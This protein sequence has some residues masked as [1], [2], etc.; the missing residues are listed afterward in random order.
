MLAMDSASI[1]AWLQSQPGGH[2]TPEPGLGEDASPTAMLAMGRLA[3]R[4]EEVVTT[5]SDCLNRPQ[6]QLAFRQLL[7]HLS[8]GRRLRL[9]SW[10]I[11]R[12]VPDGPQ[13]LAK[14]MD[15]REPPIGVGL[16]LFEDARRLHRLGLLEAIFHPDRIARVLAACERRGRP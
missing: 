7:Q 8:L 12:P 9:L 14:L 4:L 6:V 10:L 11:E 3:D 13:I 2:E 5:N 16:T 1:E 15:G